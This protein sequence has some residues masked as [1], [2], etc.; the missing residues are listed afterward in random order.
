MSVD[1][2]SSYTLASEV[3]GVKRA[4]DICF[5]HWLILLMMLLSILAILIHYLRRRKKEEEEGADTSG[6]SKTSGSSENDKDDKRAL[7]LLLIL[8]NVIGAIL[9]LF[10]H[11]RYDLPAEILSV[12]VSVLL[13]AIMSRRD[14]KKDDGVNN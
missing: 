8:F 6:A 9:V 12:V 2:Y 13:E 14:K 3:A 1:N 10:G 11:C 7:Y 5:I 4:R